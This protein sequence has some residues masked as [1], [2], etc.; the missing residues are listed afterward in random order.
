MNLF[1]N[2]PLCVG[3]V[4]LYFKW[5]GLSQRRQKKVVQVLKFSYERRKVSLPT[6]VGKTHQNQPVIPNP[7]P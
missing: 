4:Y 1:S 3:E 2:F 7:I 5:L 6:R